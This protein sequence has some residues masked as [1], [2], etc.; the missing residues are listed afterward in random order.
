M[1][2]HRPDPSREVL[3]PP[4]VRRFLRQPGSRGPR[5][6]EANGPAVRVEGDDPLPAAG[7]VTRVAILAHWSDSVRLSRSVRT[8]VSTLVEAGY[9]VVLVSTAEEHDPLDWVDDRP[10]SVTV[11]RRPNFGYDFGSWGDRDR[12]G[13]TD[14]RSGSGADLQR[15]L[16]WT[17]RES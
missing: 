13:S 3:L 17:V 14:R 15:Q 2:D 7:T 11:I 4:R 6:L 16:G 8:I 10:D 1:A 5:V 12:S 9:R